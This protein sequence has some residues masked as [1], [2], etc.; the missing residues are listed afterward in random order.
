MYGLKDK[1]PEGKLLGQK[2]STFLVLIDTVKL[3]SLGAVPVSAPTGIA[4]DPVPGGGVWVPEMS[5]AETQEMKIYSWT[6]V[7]GKDG[8]SCA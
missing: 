3:L 1:F 6:S 7:R 5:G 4:W 8:W 2:I